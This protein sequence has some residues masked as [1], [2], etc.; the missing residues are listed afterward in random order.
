MAHLNW[1]FSL[2]AVIVVFSVGFSSIF[3][4]VSL[5]LSADDFLGETSTSVR[6]VSS[7]SAAEMV[8]CTNLIAT[9]PA[10]FVSYTSKN[11]F[12]PAG[13]SLAFSVEG[14]IMALGSIVIM[15]YNYYYVLV[16]CGKL[17]LKC[18]KKKERS[19]EISELRQ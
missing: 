3:V 15:A 17:P 6:R 8:S 5:L 10:V 9:R 19:S 12:F 16:R 1:Y 13:S 11:F 7:N 18:N 14:V 2:L 4:D